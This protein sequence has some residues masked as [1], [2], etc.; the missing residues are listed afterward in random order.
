MLSYIKAEDLKA[1]RTFIKKLI[2]ITPLLTVLLAGLSGKYFTANC[3]NWWYVIL[4]P[5][6]ITLITVLVNQLEEKK[7]RYRAVF[8]LPVSL[9]KIWSAKVILIGGYTA[10]AS[11]IH[12]FGSIVGRFVYNTSSTITVKQMIAATLLLLITSLWQIP[13]CLFVSKKL[14]FLVTLL[15]NLGGGVILD[16][17]AAS[18]SYWW[19]CPYSWATRLMC[20]VLGVLPQGILADES[21]PLRNAGVIPIGVLL[22]TSLFLLLLCFTAS[23]FK[24]QEVK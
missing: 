23:W 2:I 15:L 10:A 4:F 8:A 3:Y 19:I 20:P 1:K 7:M 9:Q 11:L 6:F 13:L 16:I 17:L 24:K 22:S 5:G 18:E 21:D 12:M 14:G